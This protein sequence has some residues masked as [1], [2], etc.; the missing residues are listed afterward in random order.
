MSTSGARLNGGDAKAERDVG[1][2]GGMQERSKVGLEVD[3]RSGRQDDELQIGRSR[4]DPFARTGPF[5]PV[6]HRA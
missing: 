1:G 2:Y 3:D 6:Y 5:Q 4:D